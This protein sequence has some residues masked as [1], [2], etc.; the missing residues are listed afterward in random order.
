MI[1]P[2]TIKLLRKKFTKSKIILY[3]YDSIKNLKGILGRVELYDRVISFD[4][5]DCKNYG[6]DFR[7][8]FCDLYSSEN[9]FP[10]IPVYDICFYGTMYGDRLQIINC[11]KEKCQ[12]QSL[13]FYSFCFLCGKFM[14]V[15]YL[16]TNKGYRLFDKRNI[17]YIPKTLDE[18]SNI[19]NKTKVVLDINSRKQTGLT[20]RTL[21]TLV[22]GKKIITTNESIKEYDIYDSRNVLVLDRDRIDEFIIPVEF[23]NSP[24]CDLL[25]KVLYRYTVDGWIEDV[26]LK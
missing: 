13:K 16:F 12:E 22:S 26:F 10:N 9:K 7:P 15:Y 8:L 25:N 21:E 11:I 20:I 2:K 19:V 3:L 1:T 18:I 5:L 4:P 24:F 6:F 17:S 14:S 23:I